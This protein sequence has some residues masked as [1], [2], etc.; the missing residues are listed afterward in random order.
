MIVNF[1][2]QN[3]RS[4][5]D[6]VTLSFEAE[7]LKDLDKYYLIQATPKLKLLKL[8]LI[9][10]HNATGKTTI[11]KALDFL[12]KLVLEP[13]EKKTLSLKYKPFLFDEKT[14]NQN[15]NLS[16]EFIQNKTKY[17]YEVE[18]NRDAIVKEK[19]YFF[20]PNKALVFS[21]Q[22]NLE[23][24]LSS[25]KFG[26][27]ISINKE[28]K[29]TLEANTLWNNTVLGGYLKTNFESNELQEAI[30][31]FEHTLKPLITPK[32]D[33]LAYISNKIEKEE[34]NKANIVEF[35]TK[36]DFKITDIL[37][38]KD[39]QETSEELI[40]FFQKYSKMSEQKIN[41]DNKEVSYTL[42]YSDESQGTQRYYQFSGLLDFMIR[43]QVVF[44]IDE[45]ESS[46]HPDLLEHF[47]LS[48]LVNTQ[49][50]QIIATT[51]YREFLM[52]KDIFRNDVIWFADKKTDGSTDLFSLTDF[53]SSIIRNTS[54][55]YN[56][57]KTGKLGAVPNLGD[58]YIDTTDEEG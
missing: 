38:K 40:E 53:D 5:K 39:E 42:S 13:A 45:L 8:G 28:H 29:S 9:F 43:N 55:I 57:Y 51:H 54:S 30:N 4:I 37:I 52:K 11:L 21:R 3:Y 15:T 7:N 24:Q 20:K 34:I 47:I 48:F 35:L 17:L 12:R 6:E 23:K 31:W 36:A 19:L 22:T 27:K 46:L 58:T 49:K 1:S 26:S 25:I 10:G 2:I 33:L 14:V 16:L 41:E 50:S 18:F 32:T 56:A 44:S